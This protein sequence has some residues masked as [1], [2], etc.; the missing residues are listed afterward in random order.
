MVTLIRRAVEKGDFAE[1]I[2]PITRAA[3][4]QFFSLPFPKFLISTVDESEA[5][6]I[7]L[8]N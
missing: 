3:I 6:W 2:M 1:R 8:K 4:S 5:K 7:S